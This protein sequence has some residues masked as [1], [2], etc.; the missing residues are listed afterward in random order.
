MQTPQTASQLLAANANVQAPL[1][2][3]HIVGGYFPSSAL[4]PNTTLTTTDCEYADGWAHAQCKRL[5]CCGCSE[6][7]RLGASL[8]GLHCAFHLSQAPGWPGFRHVTQPHARL[9]MCK[10]REARATH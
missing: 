2:G 8:S 5:D 1:I 10:P 6:V 4:T 7:T 9:Q 3:Y